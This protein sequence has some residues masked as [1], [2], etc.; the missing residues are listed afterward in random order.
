[1][2]AGTGDSG[3]RPGDVLLLG[4]E[5][6]VVLER[7]GPRARVLTVEGGRK[8]VR[9]ADMD[10][11]LG[12]TLD[13]SLGGDE[14]LT[15][16]R[17]LARRI[18][19]RRD[20]VAAADLWELIIDEGEDERTAADLASVW[21]GADRRPEDTP[22]VARALARASAH[23]GRRG[24]RFT[25][26]APARVTA[27]LENEAR[28]KAR[29]EA[30]SRAV[31]WIRA[32]AASGGPAP[33]PEDL[34]HLMDRLRHAAVA[35]PGAPHDAET[36]ALLKALGLDAGDALVELLV[37]LGVL[38]EHVNLL[39]PRHGVPTAFGAKVRDEA[40][41][42]GEAASGDLADD[43]TRFVV[44]EPAWTVDDADTLERDD[45][46]SLAAAPDGGFVLGVHITDL[47]ALIPVDGLLDEEA[48]RRAA[49]LYL[50]E[51]ALPM[52]PVELSHGPASLEPGT[53]RRAVS[54]LVELAPDLTLRSSRVARTWISLAGARTYDEVRLAL[55]ADGQ[56]WTTLLTLARKLRDERVAA[57]A[58]NREDGVEPKVRVV[59]GQVQLGLIRRDCPAR[60]VVSEL[61]ILANRLFAERLRDAAAPCVYRVQEPPREGESDRRDAATFRMKVRTSLDPKPHATLGVPLYA[62][63][64]SPLR[65]YGDLLVQRQLAAVTQGRTPPYDGDR[66]RWL[67]DATD[68]ALDSIR[69][70]ERWSV[71]Y[72]ILVHL[73]GSQGQ[74]VPATVRDRRQ[75]GWLVDLDGVA[76]PVGGVSAQ[77]GTWEAGAKVSVRITD[78]QPRRGFIRVEEVV[79]TA[80][81]EASV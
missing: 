28:Q 12:L 59:D 57:G 77:S 23:F 81:E 74:V 36:T 41:R 73:R 52:L 61:M 67:V 68:V 80:R 63:A 44:D 30:T 33:V 66:L 14:L 70:I 71:R 1:M 4:V 32:T 3:S 75:D 42:A 48:R 31:A 2:A 26:K 76:L 43:D 39:V 27:T 53:R 20:Q 49:T 79:E 8:G 60:F 51:G 46:L 11:P 7:Q 62:Q 10:G 35:G 65:R 15:R 19:E 21:F 22:A 69:S 72:W 5:P 64:T 47:A 9:D 13:A 29:D 17:D 54:A 50:P 40:I 16:L 18:D 56:P 38:D 55:D 37:R 24:L 34:T 58:L 45:A 25:P 78:V 6:V